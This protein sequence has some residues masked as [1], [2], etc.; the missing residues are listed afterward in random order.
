MFRFVVLNKE[1]ALHLLWVYFC[2]LN[3]FVQ[4]FLLHRGLL[5]PPALGFGRIIRQLADDPQGVTAQR[6]NL[7]PARA[8]ATGF[9]I[10]I[11]Y[12]SKLLTD[13]KY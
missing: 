4:M 8:G 13:Y 7:A 9:N 6:K 5:C 3:S 1:K 11:P 2:I 12:K 10:Y